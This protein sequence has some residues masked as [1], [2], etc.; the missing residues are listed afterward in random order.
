VGALEE[1]GLDAVWVGESYGLDAI[2]AMGALAYATRRVE[3]C[4]GILNL[5]GRTPATTAMSMAGVDAL[6]G[7]RA[8]LGLGASGPQAV[9]GWHGVP[10]DAPL[11]RAREIIDI[12]RAI[13]R[14][15]RVSHSGPRYQLPAAGGCGRGK[16]LRLISEPVRPRIPVFLAALGPQNVAL[17]SEV[18]EGW[19]PVFFW[20]ERVPQVWGPALR[21]GQERRDPA[22]GPLQ[23]ATRVALGIGLADPD[24]ALA[25][26]RATV[27]RYV[28]SQGARGRELL[29]HAAGPVRVPR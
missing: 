7:G 16:P 5:Y 25:Q 24:S 28:G 22:L 14:R 17:A 8:V 23:V 29:L 27:A 11:G 12:C 9:E 2:S 20:P 15:E 6:S 26:E 19:L 1:A 4:S 3:I 10:Y 18:A 13:W 21:A